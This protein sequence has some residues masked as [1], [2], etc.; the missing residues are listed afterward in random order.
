ME[1]RRQASVSNTSSLETCLKALLSPA[2]FLR[3][4]KAMLELAIARANGETPI[5]VYEPARTILRALAAFELKTIHWR[6]FVDALRLGPIEKLAICPICDKLFLR[7][8]KDTAACGQRCA[9]VLRVRRWRAR[10]GETYK[11]R[12]DEKG[13]ETCSTNAENS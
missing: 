10:Y 13:R 8:R 1:R 4:K 11:L 5:P 7:G 9:N 3:V 6:T 2:D 12:R